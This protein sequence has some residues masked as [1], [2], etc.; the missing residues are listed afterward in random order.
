MRKMKFLTIAAALFAVSTG[1]TSCS[2]SDEPVNQPVSVSGLIAEDLT[3]IV[4]S[5]AEAEFSIDVAAIAEQDPSKLAAK[6]SA[7]K[8]NTAKVTAKLV[9]ATGYAYSSQTAIVNFS[10]TNT[11][12]SIAFDFAKGSTETASQAEVAASTTDIVLTSNLSDVDAAMI[13]PA[14]TTI[15]SG[16]SAEDF[17]VTATEMP[18]EVIADVNVGQV[19]NGTK[20]IALPCTP[21]GCTFSNNIKLSLFVG[22]S[23]AGKP[24][25]IENGAD[26]VTTTVDADGNATFEVSHF[27]E[28]YLILND[29][30]VVKKVTGQV[31]L[32]TA[33][34]NVT[35]GTNM[36]S[37]VKNLGVI[38]DEDPLFTDCVNQKLGQNYGKTE[39]VG[40]FYADKA[41][42]VSLSV[43]QT[44]ADYTFDY[45]GISFTA[46]RWEAVTATISTEGGQKHS[47]GVGM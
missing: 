25:T 28:W 19:I 20:V 14:G 38:V 3:I 42:R 26:K 33:D 18:A 13:I 40:S 1:L 16:S 35:Q 17:S 41:G 4:T 43:V 22:K 8:A 11:N 24:L 31:S 2:S 34:L 9:D 27:S 23:L 44:Y 36:F 12:V 37:Y 29:V 45:K 10:K 6:F 32:L 30:T 5:N 39:E 47:A 15:T 21:D 7:V 46:R